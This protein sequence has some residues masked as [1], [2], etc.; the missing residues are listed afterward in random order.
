[1]SNR[2]SHI[3]PPAK[4]GGKYAT[5]IIPMGDSCMNYEELFADAKLIEKEMAERMKTQQRL[6]KSIQK[7]MEAGDLK[8]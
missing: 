2:M 1:M 8:A 6:A 4:P 3:F 7:S 5:E